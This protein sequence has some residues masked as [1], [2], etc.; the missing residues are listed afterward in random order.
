MP[1]RSQI[2]RCR[3]TSSSFA[4]SG[5]SVG[6]MAMVAFG[7]SASG[8]VAVAMG[9]GSDPQP[10]TT[11]ARTTAMRGPAASGEARRGWTIGPSGHPGLGGRGHRQELHHLDLHL[12]VVRVDVVVDVDRGREAELLVV[13]H[14][15]LVRGP[16]A[17][18][19]VEQLL[20][21]DR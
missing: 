8:G 21:G 5:A 4:G 12:V 20:D 16:V 14:A 13:G 2:A 6:P 19:Q 3:P 18:D 9:F 10:A 11:R 7:C 1:A 15:E 17:R